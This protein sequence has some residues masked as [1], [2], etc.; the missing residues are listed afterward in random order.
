M[1]SLNRFIY[2]FIEINRMELTHGGSANV[3]LLPLTVPRDREFSHAQ[4]RIS[5]TETNGFSTT[6]FPMPNRNDVSGQRFQN[7]S[8][9]FHQ[10]PMINQN[11]WDAMYDVTWSNTSHSKK[12]TPDDGFRRSI[13]YPTI[14]NNH[15]SQIE[16]CFNSDCTL[17]KSMSTFSSNQSKNPS[18]TDNKGRQPQE[19]SFADQW[20]I[21]SFLLKLIH[22]I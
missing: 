6:N 8:R 18:Q 22:L 11:S 13:H 14:T 4:C 7:V 12:S 15:T 5:S 10:N 2:F 9:D 20:V 16:H 19:N 1:S 3:G 21:S 17:F